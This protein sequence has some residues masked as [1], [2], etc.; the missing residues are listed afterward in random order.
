MTNHFER[1]TRIVELLEVEDMAAP[2][3]LEDAIDIAK[4]CNT[5]EPPGLPVDEIIQS[6]FKSVKAAKGPRNLA[7]YLKAITEFQ[8]RTELIRGLKRLADDEVGRVINEYRDE[9]TG[10]IRLMVFDP[11]ITRLT[12]TAAMTATGDTSTSLRMAGKITAAI[13]LDEATEHLATV[14]R[15]REMWSNLYPDHTG[16]PRSQFL[17]GLEVPE[18]EPQN[19]T[20]YLERLRQGLTPW[21]PTS[22]NLESE[23]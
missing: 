7:R 10:T 15:C 18:L 21:L 16:H 12:R 19:D 22:T 8:A 11:A 4:L 1:A 23:E 20:G 2:P 17:E 5:L 3:G 6:A 13:A 14:Q 9:I